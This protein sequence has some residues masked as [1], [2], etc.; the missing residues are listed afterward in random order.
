ML[1][2]GYKKTNFLRFKPEIDLKTLRAE[3]DAISADKWLASYWGNIHCSIGML[4]LRGG[5]KGNSEDFLC[6]EVF[7]YPILD[8]MPY[9]NYLISKDGPFGEAIYAFIF[10]TK[11]NGVTLRHQDTIEKWKDMYRIHVPIYTN[12]GAFLIANKHS[13]HFSAGYAWSFDNQSDHGVVNGNEERSHLIFD[14]PYSEKMRQQYD[15]ATFFKGQID[16]LNLDLITNKTKEVK[17]YLG[18]DEMIN[19]IKTLRQRGVNDSD[20]AVFFNSKE[21]PTK[22]HPVTAWDAQ[23]VKNL[24][25]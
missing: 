1:P 16:T 10:K 21:I 13:Q 3:F 7:D 18:D 4:L 20:I 23:M 9:I 5:N 14:V 17:S 12:P 25:P 24:V 6:D 22:N 2:S 19:A 11:P 15:D 8:E